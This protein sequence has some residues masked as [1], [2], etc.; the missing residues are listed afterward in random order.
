M[1]FSSNPKEGRRAPREEVCYRC[2]ISAPALPATAALIVNISPYGCMVRCSKDVQTGTRVSFKLPV[3]GP[4]EGL[5]VWA[6]GGR[7]GLEYDSP[8]PLQPY[9]AMLGEM[10]RS[11][12]EMGLY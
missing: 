9:L 6:I 2:Q 5:I 8:I 3:I 11:G 4:C 1:P 12:D 10:S 7:L